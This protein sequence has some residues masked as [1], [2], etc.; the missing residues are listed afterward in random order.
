MKLVKFKDIFSGAACYYIKDIPI[1]G[2]LCRT[3]YGLSLR[4]IIRRFKEIKP[5]HNLIVQDVQGAD[6]IFI[7]EFEKIEDLLE[8]IQ[9]EFL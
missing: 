8:K 5:H 6:I 7:I 3:N 9:E 1:N 4:D 2:K